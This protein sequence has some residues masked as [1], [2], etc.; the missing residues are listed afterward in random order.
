MLV[1]Q[2]RSCE[3]LPGS[4][5]VAL[6]FLALALLALGVWRRVGLV[7]GAEGLRHARGSGRGRFHG[8][9]GRGSNGGGDLELVEVAVFAG[10]DRGR[11]LHV[12]AQEIIEAVLDVGEAALQVAERDYD[13]VVRICV[14][15][16]I[17]TKTG[18]CPRLL[19]PGR[20]RLGAR[21]WRPRRQGLG[22]KGH[23]RVA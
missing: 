5:G 22:L 7:C 4:I 10:Q 23:G 8:G 18:V 20:S 14:S 9:A 12:C 19:L 6:L 13:L 3:R 1:V 11:V 16:V 17:K 15:V 21:R 2:E